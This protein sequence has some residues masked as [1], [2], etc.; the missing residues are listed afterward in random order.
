[1]FGC[2]VSDV[3]VVLDV[4]IDG[5]VKDA[6][7]LREVMVDRTAV[8]AF[9][10]KAVV[11][12]FDAMGGPKLDDVAA[13]AGINS[14]SG[15]ATLP[16]S[17]GAEAETINPALFFACTP[18]D[19]RVRQ[20]VFHYLNI[21]PFGLHRPSDVFS[22]VG[23]HTNKGLV[24]GV[25]DDGQY[26]VMPYFEQKPLQLERARTDPHLSYRRDTPVSAEV[27][28]AC[29]RR[30]H[31]ESHG[32][33]AR[34]RMSAFFRR[35]GVRFG[36]AGRE[37]S[38]IS[39]DSCTPSA[40]GLVSTSSRL[41]PVNLPVVT[42]TTN[43]GSV[44]RA[45]RRL[46]RAMPSSVVPSATETPFSVLPAHAAASFRSSG[47][48]HTRYSTAV[49]ADA[50]P[51][52]SSATGSTIAVPRGKHSSCDEAST[53][54]GGGANPPGVG[55]LEVTEVLYA[56]RDL[57]LAPPLALHG[58]VPP[59]RVGT[60]V[61]A[62]RFG[63]GDVLHM[64]LVLAADFDVSYTIRYDCDGDVDTGVLHNDVHALGDVEDD[65]NTTRG[66]RQTRERM[67]EPCRVRDHVLVEGAQRA[68][69]AVVMAAMGSG[70]YHL[71]LVAAP[72]PLIE[73]ESRQI[74]FVKPILFGAIFAQPRHLA[75]FRHLDTNGSGCVSWKD[76]RHFV[77]SSEG[78]GQP[79]SFQR[80][81][82]LQRDMRI[83]K[84]T[85][86]PQLL[87][88]VPVQ[89]EEQQLSFRDFEYVLMRVENIL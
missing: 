56:L 82:E 41:L 85:V 78:F 43:V 13:A 36:A 22:V 75:L 59:H 54:G 50:T 87:S 25:T 26:R 10:S 29:L 7:L 37:S 35:A 53:A 81:G 2:A 67:S 18:I 3:G 4:R 55:K 79:L 69:H 8:E 16:H 73:V 57:Q 68:H 84:H 86:E 61:I 33:R 71:A 62:R 9:E 19:P 40:S 12:P 32:H 38:F 15:S 30:I 27:D 44:I 20:H 52:A 39:A 46:V 70:R 63:C 66:R 34:E 42:S 83:R 17:A 11:M 31:C 48:V 6:A 5:H 80:L 49:G 45:P 72:S 28:P 65:G 64:G 51:N 21:L 1:M 74:E 77:L 89:E 24:V 14:G 58:P 47:Q 88:K 23:R 76:V 60:R